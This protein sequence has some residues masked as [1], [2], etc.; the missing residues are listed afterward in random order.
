MAGVVER[1]GQGGLGLLVENVHLVLVQAFGAAELQPPFPGP[2]VQ[3][4]LC[5]A[6]VF[7]PVAHLQQKT[8][9]R[10]TAPKYLSSCM[11]GRDNMLL[12]I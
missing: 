6:D 7:A 8:E 12:M 2:K 1:P 10:Q 4:L 3:V 5:V 9:M 11:Q